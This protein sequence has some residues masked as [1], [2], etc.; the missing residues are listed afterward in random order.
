MWSD[1]TINV[2][3]TVIEVRVKKDPQILIGWENREFL[4]R[5]G[6]GIRYR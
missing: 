5:E 2:Q 6:D 4:T 3:F 1:F